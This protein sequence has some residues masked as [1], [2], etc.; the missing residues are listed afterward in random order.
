MSLKTRLQNDL[1]DAMRAKD[2]FK[3]DVIRFLMSA[4]KQV[5]VDSRKELDDEE[6]IKV[7]KKSVKQREEAAKQYKEGGRDDLYTKEM[8]EAQ[9]LKSY[10]PAQLSPEELKEKVKEIIEQVGATSPKDVGKVMKIAMKELGTQADGKE[11]NKIAIQLLK[12]ED[13]K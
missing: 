12:G 11:I 2:T 13:G 1:K 7:I 4:I 8:K 6:I 5:E 3:R 10:L 9:L